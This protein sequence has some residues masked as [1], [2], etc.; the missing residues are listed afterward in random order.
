ML[1]ETPFNEHGGVL[2]P[3]DRWLAYVL[4]ETGRDE[5]YV[6]SITGSGRRELV[7]TDGGTEPVWSPT[8]TELFYRNGDRMMAV[9]VSDRPELVVAKPSVLFEGPY[10]TGAP[11]TLGPNYDV[12]A[13]GKYFV[14]V[15]ED[16]TSAN[17]E[18]HVVLNW[19]EELTRVAHAEK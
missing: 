9:A 1:V 16:E 15:R 11:S 4:D 8:G 3:D 19:F 7:S 17:T 12:S 14:M 6:R 2:S 18:I 5:V 13:D 10:Q